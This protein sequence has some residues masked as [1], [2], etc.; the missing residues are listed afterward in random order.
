MLIAGGLMECGS[1]DFVFWGMGKGRMLDF[2][3]V[4]FLETVADLDF[5]LLSFLLFSFF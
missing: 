2:W 1:C 5:L 3:L 4:L